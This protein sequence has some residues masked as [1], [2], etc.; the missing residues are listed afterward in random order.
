M[1]AKIRFV[2]RHFFLL[3]GLASPVFSAKQARAQFAPQAGL[4]GS[5]AIAKDSSVIV[6]WASQCS[7]VRGW[8]DIAD[9]TLGKTTTGDSSR[10]L[11][12]ADADVVS[13]G[14]GGE[15]IFYFNNPVVNGPGA[16]FAVF[17]NGFRNPADSNEAFLELAHV[18]VSNNGLTYFPF[19]AEC[20][21][22]TL[23]QIAGAGT[24]LDARKIHNLAGKYVTWQGTPFDLDELSS[25]PALDVNDI[26][27]IK[28]K[29]AVGSLSAGFCTRDG[30]QQVINDPYPTPYATGGFDLDALAVIH[31]QTPSSI[32]KTNSLPFAFYPNPANDFIWFKMPEH[33]QKFIIYSPD[34]KIIVSGKPV[35]PLSIQQLVAG[36]YFLQVIDQK[37]YTETGTL[38]VQ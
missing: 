6:A 26:R 10:A 36:C 23:S 16:D 20:H 35:S 27:Y 2:C 19:F 33:W 7:I 28:I 17:E 34:G 22:D 37:G 12:M 30:H 13:L 4:P 5:T 1:K 29:D 25:L 31:Q 18:L 8:I 9:T 11:G 38:I 15:A 14:D 21:I 32:A 24:Y 3:I